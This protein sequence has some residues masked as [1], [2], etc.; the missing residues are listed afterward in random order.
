M[1]WSLSLQ[2]IKQRAENCEERDQKTKLFIKLKELQV[3]VGDSFGKQEGAKCSIG[4]V[5]DSLSGGVE[6][7]L[8][9][10]QLGNGQRGR[11]MDVQGSRNLYILR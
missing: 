11:G 7:H 5:S 1:Q 8:S 10:P 4:T 3:P 6:S 2:R 9:Q